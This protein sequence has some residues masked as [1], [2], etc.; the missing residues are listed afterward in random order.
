MLVSEVSSLKATLLVIEVYLSNMS[1][2]KNLVHLQTSDVKLFHV[3]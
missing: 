1:V 2:L 3:T